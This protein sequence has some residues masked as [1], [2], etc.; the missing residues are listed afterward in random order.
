MQTNTQSASFSPIATG[1]AYGM[2]ATFTT[3]KS[4]NAGYESQVIRRAL[5]DL[6]DFADRDGWQTDLAVSLLRQANPAAYDALGDARLEGLLAGFNLYFRFFEVR[7]N[8]AFK[9][10]PEKF[11]GAGFLRLTNPWTYADKWWDTVPDDVLQMAEEMLVD[12]DI[13]EFKE[14]RTAHE[15]VL[16]VRLRADRIV[17]KLKEF[18]PQKYDSFNSL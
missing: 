16:C 13:L 6:C 12:A 7:R 2:T 17:Q 3:N 15:R 10:Q 4:G 18:N 1:T 9:H 8:L 11:D 5:L 14:S